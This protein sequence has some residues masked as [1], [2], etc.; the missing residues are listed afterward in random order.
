MSKTFWYSVEFSTEGDATPIEEALASADKRVRRASDERGRLRFKRD[1]HRVN[2]LTVS[3]TLTADSW[4][5]AS[6]AGEQVLREVAEAAGIRIVDADAPHPHTASL[7][8]VESEGYSL[9]SV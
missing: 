7:P 4:S 2:R 5:A 6:D 1:E 3:I 9:A 8:L